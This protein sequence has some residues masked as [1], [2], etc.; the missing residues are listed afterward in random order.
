VLAVIDFAALW[1]LLEFCRTKQWSDAAL[2]LGAMPFAHLYILF[3]LLTTYR[4]TGNPLSFLGSHNEFTMHYYG[5]YA[6]SWVTKLIYYPKLLIKESNPIFGTFALYGV[7]LAFEKGT[8]LRLRF[9]FLL[10]ITVLGVFSIFN[11]FSVPAAAAPGRFALTFYLFLLPYAGFA[12]ARLAEYPPTTKIRGPEWLVIISIIARCLIGVNQ[13]RQPP[14][15]RSWNDALRAGYEMSGILERD[16]GG[17]LLQ[18][19]DGWEWAGVKLTAGH[20]DH[21]FFDRTFDRFWVLA[22]PSLLQA[23]PNAFAAQ[24]RSQHILLMAFHSPEL[25]ELAQKFGDIISRDHE[26]VVL[27]VSA[28]FNLAPGK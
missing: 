21:Q 7:I 22:P 4:E 16:G 14:Q 3:T 5:G 8:Q 9:L 19:D 26:W 27:R 20:F 2:H 28:E 23:D 12:F 1:L 25:V 17:Y 11:I 13:I 24:L 18:L 15:S 6:V 10:G